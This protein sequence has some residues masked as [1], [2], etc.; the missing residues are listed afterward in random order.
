MGQITLVITDAAE[1]FL[2]SK[3]A[4]HGDMGAFV[5]KLLTTAQA[6]EGEQ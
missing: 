4:K 5:S 2:R 1:S 6:L 3:N